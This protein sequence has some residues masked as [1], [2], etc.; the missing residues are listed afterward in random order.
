[1]SEGIYQAA[2]SLDLLSRLQE[3]L[4]Q[5][6]ANASTNGYRRRVGAAESFEGALRR[7]ARLG[8]PR[9]GEAIDFAPGDV[10]ETGSPLDLALDGRGFFGVETSAG[11]RYTRN[12]AFTLDAQ[13]RIVAGD[14]ARLL[15]KGGPIQIDPARGPVVVSENGEVRQDGEVRGTLRL[16]EFA[17][18][19]LLVPDETGR[20]QAPRGV[21][22]RPSTPSRVRQGYLEGSNVNVT[23][24]LVDMIAAF[25]S[26]EASQRALLTSDRVREQ[27][28]R[29]RP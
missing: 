15:G 9:Y 23:E 13:G 2:A 5:N 3:T 20:F 21:E 14:G 12:G 17:D 4:A 25:R 19:R 24:E 8:I 6:L 27:S 29:S 10:R 11:V 26:F 16:D 28:L 1:M 7:A 18:P 22:P